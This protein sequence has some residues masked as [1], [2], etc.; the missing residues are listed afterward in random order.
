MWFRL[1]VTLRRDD[2][3]SEAVDASASV[4]QQM[5]PSSDVN[6]PLGNETVTPTSPKSIGVSP[7]TMLVL[8]STDSTLHMTCN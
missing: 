6:S 4:A 7:L 5:P 8:N 2:E 3:G 1:T